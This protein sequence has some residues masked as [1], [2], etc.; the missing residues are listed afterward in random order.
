M[1]LNGENLSAYERNRLYLNAGN[2]EF[3][4]ASFASSCD[5]DADSRTAVSFDYDN[6][7]DEDILVG[8]VGGGALR[9]FKNNFPTQNSLKIKLKGVKSNSLGV[10]SRVTFM[11]NGKKISRDLFPANGFMGSGPS[12]IVFGMGLAPEIDGLEIRWPTGKVQ[13]VGK[14]KANQVVVVTEDDSNPALSPIRE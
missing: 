5:I 4:N 2:L 7:G 14:I 3:V 11:V 8:S 1:P 13:K 10:G 9:L 12:E 6:D